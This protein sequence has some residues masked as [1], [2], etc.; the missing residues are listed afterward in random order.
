MAGSSFV[1]SFTVRLEWG[2]DW[3]VVETDDSRTR[4]REAVELEWGHDWIVVETGPERGAL[5]D[6]LVLEW[7]HD[8]IVVETV[9]GE[10]R[11]RARDVHT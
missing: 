7:G 10:E 6:E 5:R 4:V 1:T 9:L 11:A 2:H 8:W 3:I